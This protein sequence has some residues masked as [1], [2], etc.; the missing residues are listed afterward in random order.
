MY[1]YGPQASRPLYELGDV[2][3][4]VLED[5][6][7]TVSELMQARFFAPLRAFAH[8]HGLTLRLQAHGAPADLISTYGY[9]DIPETEDL[10]NGPEPDFL[11]FARAAADIY[12]K[13]FA[14]AESMILL[15]HAIDAPPALYKA[16]AD[17]FFISGI[18]Q[19]VEHGMPYP[20][21]QQQPGLGWAPFGALFGNDFDPANPLFDMLGPLN[22][23]VARMQAVI[24]ATHPIV[25]VALYEDM[26][27]RH[28][29]LPASEMREAPLSASLRGHG[30]TA[31]ALTLDGLLKSHADSKRLRTPGGTQYAAIVVNDAGSLDARAARAL[32]LAQKAGVRVLFLGQIPRRA[33]G[34]RPQDDAAVRNDVASL[35]GTAPPAT[36]E[37]LPALL[38]KAGV[39]S[40]ITARSGTLPN[41]ALRSDGKRIYALLVNPDDATREMDVTIP[42]HGAVS[43]WSAWTG[44]MTPA[45]VESGAGG[46]LRASLPAYGSAL[47]VIDPGAAPASAAAAA[48][49]P[50][51]LAT[52]GQ[53]GWNVAARGFNAAGQSVDTKF[54][55]SQLTDWRGI[56]ALGAFSGHAVYETSLQALPVAG[57]VLID[58]G[59][60]RG[61]ARVTL[62]GCSAGA[63][64]APYRLD[65]TTALHPGPNTL[66]ITVGS[67]PLN[68]ESNR[69]PDG[70]MRFGATQ[71]A[72]L[73]GPVQLL[74]ATGAMDGDTAAL[75][76]RH[77]QEGEGSSSFL[78]K[79]TKKLLTVGIRGAI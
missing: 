37:N 16:R 52:I 40:L 21:L 4:R 38:A 7:R 22:D 15:G 39:A 77:K 20:Y 31:D 76:C 69:S 70:L 79:R 30:Y 45:P 55:L 29:V 61:A 53:G 51:E 65:I 10:Y 47:Y 57:H 62:N 18:G 58:L 34:L 42:Q 73:L 19:L 27:F 36:V 48:G 68:G 8:A 1:P 71:P 6:H 23:Y 56:S 66:E 5:Y 9:A 54:S 75:R 28:S 72:G 17:R 46:E 24:R 67:T 50:Q 59:D 64:M 11:S 26:L 49:E 12:G 74:R 41:F 78:K 14:S 32:L 63:V 2:G 25:P 3:P 35:V 44:T 60:V 43:R 33:A 13:K